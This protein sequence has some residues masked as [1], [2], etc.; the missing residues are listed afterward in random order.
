MCRFKGNQMEAASIQAPHCHCVCLGSSLSCKD[1]GAK[2]VTSNFLLHL[3]FKFKP[4]PVLFQG[5]WLRLQLVC[6]G[7]NPSQAQA[8]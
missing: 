4:P 6:A 2:W 7:A 3:S 1:D 8:H 5:S